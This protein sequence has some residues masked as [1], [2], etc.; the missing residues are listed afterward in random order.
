MF[1]EPDFAPALVLDHPDPLELQ[2]AHGPGQFAEN[3][4]G[5]G[6]AQPHGI[7]GLE[8]DL[9]EG[10]GPQLHRRAMPARELAWGEVEWMLQHAA[11][12][13]APVDEI[14]RHVDQPGAALPWGQVQGILQ[15]ADAA[16]AP[17]VDEAV[18]PAQEAQGAHRSHMA[19]MAHL[20][21]M[22]PAPEAQISHGA[23]MAHLAEMAPAP[24]DA[25]AHAAALRALYPNQF[26]IPVPDGFDASMPGHHQHGNHHPSVDWRGVAVLP[27]VFGMLPY[28]PCSGYQPT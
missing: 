16:A 6:Q 8:P 24:V 22:A 10:Q 2:Q 4:L 17:R 15:Q 9:E 11:G 13:G 21:Q 20:A 12:P 25:V 23:L 18:V 1:F 3:P 26:A 7:E 28:R 14:L 5:E 19:L 27:R